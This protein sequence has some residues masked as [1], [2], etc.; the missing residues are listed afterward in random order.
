ML[1]SFDEKVK[2]AVKPKKF[3]FNSNSV[4]Y[5]NN[6]NKIIIGSLKRDEA[7]FIPEYVF[8]FDNNVKQSEKDKILTF[9]NNYSYIND[10]I[11]H[12][13]CQLHLQYQV[14]KLKNEQDQ[15]IGSLIILIQIT[16]PSSPA[17]NN[18]NNMNVVGK[19]NEIQKNIELRKNIEMENQQ[20]KKQEDLI[21][22]NNLVNKINYL[23]EELKKKENQNQ[24]IINELNKLKQENALL[25]KNN[26]ENE[27]LSAQSIESIMYP[28]KINEIELINFQ[29]KEHQYN[30]VNKDL[31]EKQNILNQLNKNVEDL[32][33][34]KNKLVGEINQK[35]AEMSNINNIINLKDNFNKEINKLKK[36]LNQKN[37][38]LANINAIKNNFENQNQQ[39]ISTK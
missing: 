2:N 31:K 20:K 28:M 15:P 23:N 16:P 34:M 7:K 1:K 6:P 21:N 27:I 13:K 19:D 37:E 17:K 25:I 29:K 18:K 35:K 30:Q 10:Y 3:I 4:Y 38:G 5:I 8:E 24:N 14:Q 12:K 33:Q 22:I 9:Q 36:E 26:K 39:L 11:I 32:Y